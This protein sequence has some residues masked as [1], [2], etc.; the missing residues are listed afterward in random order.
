M[1]KNKIEMNIYWNIRCYIFRKICISV[2]P[3]FILAFSPLLICISVY[4]YPHFHTIYLTVGRGSLGHLYVCVCVKNLKENA[5]VRP[6]SVQGRAL[7]DIHWS[8]KWV[9]LSVGTAHTEINRVNRGTD[10]A[11]DTPV[12][13]VTRT[14]ACGPLHD[15]TRQPMCWPTTRPPP[16]SLFNNNSK[17]ILTIQI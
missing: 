15:S 16:L 14:H 2:T 7:Q 6:H 4:P 1:S 11:G 3:I 9:L 17:G 10:T 5:R 12:A 13:V 8:R